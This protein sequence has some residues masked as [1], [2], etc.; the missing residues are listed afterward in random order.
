MIKS[1]QMC[2]LSL[3]KIRLYCNK[4]LVS[5]KHISQKTKDLITH[6]YYGIIV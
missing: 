4:E 6:Y 2:W 5:H 3:L 1:Y